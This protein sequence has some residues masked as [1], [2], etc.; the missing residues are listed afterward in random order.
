MK[1][2]KSIIQTFL[3]VVL[4][5]VV[6]FSTYAGVLPSQPNNLTIMGNS[7]RGYVNGTIQN[8]T[9]GYIYYA[10]ISQVQST[11]K[12]LAIVGNVSGEYALE[13]AM[14][15]QIY[16]WV[17]TTTTG[18][19][20]ATKE[21][22]DEVAATNLF[23]GG[24]PYWPNVSC[25]NSSMIAR[26]TVEFNHSAGDEDAYNRTFVDT[27]FSTPSFYVGEKLVA[28]VNCYGVNLKVANQTPAEAAGARNWTQVVLT[29]WTSED[30]SGTP[31]GGI[32]H[33]IIYAALIQNNSV[34]YNSQIYDFQM[35][36][37]QSGV[38]GAVSNV[39]FYFYVE[40][41]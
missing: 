5:V 38:K 26:E 9:R 3:V 21:A 25:A 40:L 30:A 41:V 32:S 7:T 4:L 15:S 34:G 10:N 11:E 17:I 22:F 37:P 27:G 8:K 28:D 13:D 39:P 2:I 16:D 23:G 31:Y 1:P 18:E 19:V 20:Y 24:I 33:D 29:D 6:V 12:W 14:G 35:L 36:L